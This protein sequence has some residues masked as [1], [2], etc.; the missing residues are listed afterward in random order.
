[1]V[2]SKRALKKFLGEWRDGRQIGNL[3]LVIRWPRSY[4]AEL[5]KLKFEGSNFNPD[6]KAV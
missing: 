2:T 3:E 1:M 6:I 5:P 4:D